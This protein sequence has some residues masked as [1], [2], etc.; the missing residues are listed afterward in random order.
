MVNIC[1][2]LFLDVG[3]K[4]FELYE[5]IFL[6]FISNIEKLLFVFN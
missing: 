5:F 1:L 4:E 6:Y 2:R 3:R